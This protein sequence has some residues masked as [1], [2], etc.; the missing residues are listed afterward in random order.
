MRSK[1]NIISHTFDFMPKLNFEILSEQKFNLCIIFFIF[2][3][4]NYHSVKNDKLWAEVEACVVNSEYP[5]VE[6][7]SVESKE[8]ST[9]L[10]QKDSI[11]VLRSCHILFTHRFSAFLEELLS[12]ECVTDLD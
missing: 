10:N 1:Q 3:Q 12:T 5:N 9:N 2:D 4:K 11:I 7:S 6:H 8:N